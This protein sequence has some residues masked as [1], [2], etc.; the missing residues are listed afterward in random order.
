M[1]RRSMKLFIAAMIIIISDSASACETQHR[2]ITPAGQTA[3][4]IRTTTAQGWS[5]ITDAQGRT[6]AYVDHRS[7][8][9]TAPN[10]RTQ[11]YVTR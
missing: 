3:A 7:G 1:R 4:Q 8:R 6:Q 2:I 11:G 10:G 9:I 5:R